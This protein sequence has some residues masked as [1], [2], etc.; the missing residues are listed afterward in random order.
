MNILIVEDHIVLREGVELFLKNISKIKNTYTASNGKEALALVNGSANI[1]LLITDLNMPEMTGFE[2]IKTVKERHPKIKIIVLTMYYN[3]SIVN[4]LKKMKI[5]AFLTKNASL[6]ELKIAIDYLNNNEI[7]YITKE[8][9]VLFNADSLNTEEGTLIKDDFAK[10][11]SLSNRETEVLELM[12]ENLSN[13]E[14]A[15]KLFIG[16]ETVKSHRK[17]IY[18]KLGV[19]NIL[20]LYKLLHSNG[21]IKAK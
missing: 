20:D 4:R 2:L 16:F 14:I 13:T 19:N 10:T 8:V 11:N 9:N 18:R 1:D 7:T 3:L 21:L 12:I 17:N 5:N 15:S 6:T